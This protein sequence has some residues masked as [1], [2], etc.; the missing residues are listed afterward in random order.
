MKS[1]LTPQ[2]LDHLQGWLTDC[3][4]DGRVCPSNT[5]IAKRFKFSSVATAAKAVG[6]LEK[7]GR[8]VVQRG[9]TARQ[10]TIIGTG[11]STAQIRQI[12]RVVRKPTRPT[13]RIVDVFSGPRVVG[14][15]GRQC[16]WIEGEPSG[17]D[18]CKC[19]RETALGVSWCPTHR[20]R[21]F[22]PPEV[23]DQRFGPLR[24]LVR[25]QVVRRIAK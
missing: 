15:R 9:W 19:L 13:D 6:R 25:G 24:G 23:A 7:Q 8:I 14:P 20:M 10:V 11:E 17:D 21:I 1:L 2:L 4:A 12:T 18:S 22:L 5:E 16:Q 3:A